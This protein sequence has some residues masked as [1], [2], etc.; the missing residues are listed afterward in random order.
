MVISKIHPHC[1][2]LWVALTSV[3]ALRL[4][5]GLAEAQGDGCWAA[6]VVFG[7]KCKSNSGVFGRPGLKLTE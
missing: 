4:I 6:L 1:L 2:V 7:P 3:S 5:T